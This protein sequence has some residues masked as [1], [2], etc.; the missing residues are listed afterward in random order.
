MTRQISS[1]VVMGV[2][3]CGKSSVARAVAERV[4]GVLIEG[5]A[6]HPPENVD[7]MA[8]GI[9]LTDEDR[10]GWLDRLGAEL[11]RAASRGERAVLACSALKERYRDRLR[12]ATASLG[13]VFL[14]LPQSAALQRV[15]QR[16]DHFMPVSLVESQ[17]AA[18]E[19]PVTEPLT[20][21][22]DGT[23]SLASIVADAVAWCTSNHTPASL[24]RTV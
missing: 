24:M 20:L 12:A 5:D 21:T 4:G 6:F 15:A 22:V 9:P 3:G 16:D 2:A 17:F 1:V 11:E 18:L 23:R 14:D 19:P 7:K 13:F 10:A 8:R